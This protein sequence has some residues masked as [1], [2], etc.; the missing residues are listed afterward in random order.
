M[1]II[2]RGSLAGSYTMTS[3][4]AIWRDL[5]ITGALVPETAS[6]GPSGDIRAFDVRTGALVWRQHLRSAILI[7]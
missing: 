6:R 5:V 7:A 2:C 3:P 1:R 4:P